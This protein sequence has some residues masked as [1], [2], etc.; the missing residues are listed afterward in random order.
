MN[1]YFVVYYSQLPDK[2][3]DFVRS[4]KEMS[5]TKEGVKP[6]GNAAFPR[7]IIRIVGGSAGVDKDL[8]RSLLALL[9]KLKDEKSIINFFIQG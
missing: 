9:T 4:R 6:L 2:L 7:A 3:T 1:T 5:M 8:Q